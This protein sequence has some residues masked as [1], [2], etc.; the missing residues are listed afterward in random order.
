MIFLKGLT[1]SLREIFAGML[2]VEGVFLKS[3]T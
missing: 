3:I 2:L 1:N